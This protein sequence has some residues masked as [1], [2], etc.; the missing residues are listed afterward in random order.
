MR[1]IKLLFCLLPILFIYS[2]CSSD[3]N[4]E[5]PTINTDNIIGTWKLIEY[6]AN[7]EA[8]NV[9]QGQVVSTSTAIHEGNTFNAFTEFSENPNAS[10][11]TGNFMALF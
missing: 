7:L 1:K 11:N 3:D 2:S 10:T 9:L 4:E 6:N 8:T 5:S